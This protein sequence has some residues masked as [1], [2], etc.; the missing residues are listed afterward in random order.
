MRVRLITFRNAKVIRL[1]RLIIE[2]IGTAKDIELEVKAGRLIVTPVK[3]VRSGWDNA[4]RE[5][6]QCGDD[7][8]LDEADAHFFSERDEAL[9][10]W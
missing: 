9:W 3:A 6:H 8:L 7:R 4:L 10:T 1:P 2:Q 5:M